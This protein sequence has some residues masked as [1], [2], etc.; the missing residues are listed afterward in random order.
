VG[1]VTVSNATLHNMD[2][3]ER[4]DVRVGD[5]VVIRRAG[6]VIPQVVNV[7]L[8]RRPKD[9]QRISLPLVCPECGSGISRS[10]DEAVARCTG[11]LYCSAQ[12]K[13][14]IKHFASRKAMDIEGLGDK[15]VDLLVDENLVQNVADIF[16]LQQEQLSDLERMGEKSARNLLLALEKSK[17]TRLNHFIYS[18]GIREVGEAT[19]LN[20][21]NHFGSLEKVIAASE[22]ELLEVSDIGPIVAKHLVTFFQ[23]DHNLEIIAA[24]QQA[25]MH[26]QDQK[27]VQRD[28]LPLAGK[29]FVLTG[30]LEQMTREQAKSELQMLGAKVSG[31]VSAKTDCLVAGSNAG[32]KLTKAQGL[33]VE[34]I[35]ED[36]FIARLKAWQQ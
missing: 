10:E 20:L 5:T 34:I 19:A 6:D 32:S 17:D 35:D 23:Q 7:V 12:R 14:A 30:T 24:L 21:A 25:G 8:E 16:H 22:E 13:Q 27:T 2:E 33:D 3:V 18:L 15:L 28:K 4:L 31:S 1:G 26:W 11:G 36:S 29:T 9:A